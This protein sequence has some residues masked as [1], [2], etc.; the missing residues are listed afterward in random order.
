MMIYA[1]APVT[2]LT[3]SSAHI[4]INR[5]SHTSRHILLVKQLFITDSLC[6]VKKNDC[7]QLE[8]TEEDLT[9]KSLQTVRE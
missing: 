2:L 1:L 6:H 4:I 3:E 9:C 7:R 5:R 8:R